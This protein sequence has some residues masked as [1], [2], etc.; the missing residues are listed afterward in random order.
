MTTTQTAVPPSRKP[1]RVW[2][3]V[4]ILVLQVVVQ[5]VVP[6]VV[7]DSV[8]IGFLGGLAAALVLLLWWLL[9]S[10]APW[11]ER[12][13]M[14][15]L[16]VAAVALTRRLV[17]RSV[18]TGA[19]GML[20]YVLAVPTLSLAFGAAAVA[21]RNWAPGP[22]RAILAAGILLGCGIWTLIRTGGFTASGH[23]DFSWRWVQTPEER[24]LAQA[25]DEP[26]PPAAT[27]VPEATAPPPVAATPEK[28]PATAASA[29]PAPLPAPVEE[30]KAG[31][32]WPGFRGSR[33]DGIVTGGVAI[34][35]DWATSPPVELWRQPI[36]PGW[37]SFAVRGGRVYTQ[38]Q[39]GEHEVVACYD[40][41]T[42]KA[43]WKH[44]DP[45]RFWESNGGAGPR[46]TPTLSNGRVYALGGTGIVNVLDARSG[47]VVWSRNAAT[48][49][50]AKVPMW[51]FAGS[52]LVLDDLVVVGASGNLVAYDRATGAPRWFGPKG[53]EGYSSP[54]LVTIDGVPQVLM[55]SGTGISSVSPADGTVLWSHEWKGYPIV[56]PGQTAEGDVLLSVSDSSGLRRLA[57]AHK[58]GAWSVEER[59]TTNG[60]KPYFNDFVVH[61]GHAYGFDG[62]IVACIDL[63]DGARKW[64]GGRY[65]NGQLVLLP[66][67]DLL[68]ILA[69]EGD[70]ALVKATPDKHTELARVPALTGKTWGHPVVVG[71]VLLARNGEEMAAFRL[72]AAR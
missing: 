15:V 1:L 44:R 31:P 19:M 22:R 66:D 27:P 67:Q 71:D 59:W 68:L 45:A 52:P 51:G 39:R 49:T 20:F 72:P 63:A 40:A 43:V 70:L 32:D 41:A 42:G 48:D 28:A 30:V 17:D 47:A 50:G 61:K 2:P 13:G 11:A 53:R 8:A 29:A 12:L 14:V 37:S 55:V 56:Q 34:A 9:F 60:L 16:M 36:G 62:S 21:A 33:R 3:A 7:P 24:L 54:Q 69:E 38:E 25:A 35:T 65:G 26:L 46:A 10:R 64:K 5:Y 4:A 6:E 23:N 57:A 58:A 18:S